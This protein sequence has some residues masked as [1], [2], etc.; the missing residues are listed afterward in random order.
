MQ[1]SYRN[2]L[3]FSGAQRALPRCRSSEGVG[4]HELLDF[5]VVRK[6]EHAGGTRS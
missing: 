6:R 2:T 3:Q 4:G 5:T 1:R